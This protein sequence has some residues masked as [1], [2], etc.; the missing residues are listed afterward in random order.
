M[1][2]TDFDW[3]RYKS[4]DYYLE[5]ENSEHLKHSIQFWNKTLSPES[6]HKTDYSMKDYLDW[7]LLTSRDIF[8]EYRDLFEK[9]IRLANPKRTSDKGFV[10]LDKIHWLIYRDVE[11]QE[12]VYIPFI[13][14][15]TTNKIKTLNDNKIYEIDITSQEFKDRVKN[16]T[17]EIYQALEEKTFGKKQKTYGGMIID[18]FKS[19]KEVEQKQQLHTKAFEKSTKITTEEML[20]EKIFEDCGFDEKDTEI[21]QITKNQPPRMAYKHDSLDEQF[22]VANTIYFDEKNYVNLDEL[23]DITKSLNNFATAEYQ[24]KLAQKEIEK[25]KTIEDDNF[26]KILKNSKK[27][28]SEF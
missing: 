24:F 20:Y 22:I 1:D 25:L 21:K 6:G 9:K 26:D 19:K 12:V 13:F 4:S 14:N 23:D 28:I 8:H 5:I 27:Q 15:Q 11:K 10:E 7:R 18:V 3:E 16:K 17:D 2:S